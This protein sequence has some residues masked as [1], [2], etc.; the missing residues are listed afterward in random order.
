MGIMS[1]LADLKTSAVGQTS[2][3]IGFPKSTT[4][5][6]L[7]KMNER[8]PPRNLNDDTKRL[9][10]DFSRSFLSRSSEGKISYEPPKPPIYDFRL[11]S[12]PCS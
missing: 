5:R 6:A 10:K 1:T 2:K 12:T 9:L 7:S 11:P 8:S 4:S 3:T